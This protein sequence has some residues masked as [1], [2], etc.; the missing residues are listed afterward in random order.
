MFC[1][2]KATTPFPTYDLQNYNTK[3]ENIRFH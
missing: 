1:K 3:T 2:V